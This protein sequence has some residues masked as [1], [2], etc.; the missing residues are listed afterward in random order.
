M[1]L[2]LWGTPL[3][4][5][6][7]SS[8]PGGPSGG[9][10]ERQDL[11]R[12]R[13]TIALHYIVP[14]EKWLPLEGLP[15]YRVYEH[16]VY[17]IITRE[18]LEELF[19]PP[20][21]AASGEKTLWDAAPE[22]EHPP[23]RTLSLVGKEIPRFADT[24][25]RLIYTFAGGELYGL[26]SQ[27]AVF[28]EDGE[29]SLVLRAYPRIRKGVGS[30]RAVS[31]LRRRSP[32]GE[33]FYSAAGLSRRLRDPYIPLEDKWVRR[34]SLERL[35]IGPLGHYIGGEKL[36]P[37]TLRP[38]ELLL[39][40]GGRLRFLW[41]GVETPENL[42]VSSPPGGDVT[43]PDILFSHL[44]YLR[45]WGINGAVL[46][47]RREEAFQSLAVW[48]RKLAERLEGGRVLVL[49][50]EESWNACLTGEFPQREGRGLTVPPGLW[51]GLSV[52][53]RNFR[54]IGIAFYEDLLED[55]GEEPSP[56]NPGGR[57]NPLRNPGAW[58]LLFLADF[59]GS[60]GLGPG[61]P[62][63]PAAAAFLRALPRRLTLGLFFGGPDFF[64]SPEYGVIRGL[65]ALRGGLE[66]YKSYFFRAA[67]KTLPLP[68]PPDSGP[69][70]IRRPPR[71]FPAEGN[72]ITSGRL[73]LSEKKRFS[74][75]RA[76]EFLEEQRCFSLPGKM[77]DFAPPEE[78]GTPA[79]GKL[80]EARKNYF[81]FWRRLV[82]QG[83][84]PETSPACVTL[85]A[86]ELILLMG[87]E[88]MENL[89][90]LLGLWEHYRAA[91]P[92]MDRVFPPLI[93]GFAV[94]Y[95]IEDEGFSAIL[96]L[97]PVLLR[98]F[99]KS[100]GIIADLYLHKKYA[101]ENNALLLEDIEAFF[102]LPPLGEKSGGALARAL[103]A[104]DRHLR[105]F[106]HR[107]LF[108][109]FYPPLER[110][111]TLHSFD[112][113]K[114]LGES[115]YRVRRISFCQHPPLLRFLGDLASYLN[116][117]FALETGSPPGG[118][119]RLERL[120][121]F[122]VDRELAF[123][124]AAPP[125]EDLLR[126][127]MEL[128]GAML[129]RLREES[130]ELRDLLEEEETRGEG[131]SRPPLFFPEEDLRQ[132]P[133]SPKGGENAEDGLGTFLAD[134]EDPQREALTLISLGGKGEELEV[135]ALAS[136][137]MPDLL[138]DRIKRAYMERRGDLLIEILDEGPVITAE[139]K[140]E[141]KKWA[142][143]YQKG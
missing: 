80:D 60:G 65:F 12:R 50:P 27:N 35:G 64:Q 126:E 39:R 54:G 1:E 66:K 34:E 51:E 74:G 31:A 99:G 56:E 40:G 33:W 36:L 98:A 11:Y 47:T 88:P 103:N 112:E 83:R 110:E 70:V 141:L 55:L 73:I 58:D 130:D 77:A 139:Y 48:L 14:E 101:E 57:I 49:I 18:A 8:R 117:R 24:W 108:E 118:P 128:S 13:I 143:G 136:G 67:G 6:G 116:Q 135:L 45:H 92:D 90:A 22:A 37:L 52:F 123:P 59:P 26:L 134:L 75:L 41:Q 42:W 119:P 53:D 87:G 142:Q 10:P 69:P 94:L 43:A 113:F 105:K 109:Y 4:P 7:E 93:T 61:A 124:C 28:A 81:F 91:F 38:P 121:R 86:R 15:D 106:Y 137:T 96:N 97:P 78:G 32:G 29:L 84:F 131:E 111:E 85:Y 100:G 23:A 125:P 46:E 138:I 9:R 25:A 132:N 133:E 76:G 89:S 115:S 20:R 102:P 95:S 72:G 2:T 16:R 140:E 3:L 21:E 122:L 71:P 62:L 82:R 129:R 120:W 68:E 44:E 127:P 17:E 107:K 63:S 19:G 5:F 30:P 114:N 104:I 79:F